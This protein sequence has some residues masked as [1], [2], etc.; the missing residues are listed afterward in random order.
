MRAVAV[1][2]RGLGLAVVLAALAAAPA[3]AQLPGG[4]CVGETEAA[5]VEQKPGP[6]VRYGVVPGVQAGQSGAA[7]AEAVPE[8]P[9]KTDR[10]LEL[11]RPRTG[12]LF[13]RLNRLFW[14]DGEEGIARFERLVRRYARRGYLIEVQLRYHPSPQQEGDI[15]AWTE[16]V[17][18]VVRRLGSHPAVRQLQVT[19]EVTITFSPDSSDG[20]Y[21]GARDALIEG[22]IAAQDEKRRRGFGQ[23]GIGF[24]W[25]YRLDPATESG[26]WGYLR[27]RGGARFVNALDWIGLDAYPGTFFPPAE[28]PG[29]ERDGMV[30][31]FSSLRC[32]AAIPGIPATVPIHV[33]ENGWPTSAARTPERQQTA[34]AAM[35]SAVHDFRGTYN[36]TDYRWH[37]LRDGDSADPRQEQ[38]YGL[39]R[40]DYSPK[41]A[42]DTVCRLFSR[43][44]TPGGGDDCD[45]AG[46][47]LRVVLKRQ[48]PRRCAVRATLRG[49][50]LPAVA[51]AVFRVNGHVVRRD[52]DAPFSARIWRRLHRGAPNRVRVFATLASGRVVKRRP[53]V[54]PCTPRG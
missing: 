39:M 49:A 20:A 24:N 11:L 26:F 22:V 38:Q 6:P 21:Q 52:R 50:D 44:S 51:H 31:A 53:S 45:S 46:P 41:P 37:N 12:V 25:F 13:V 15:G 40:D 33:N 36:I 14:S 19:N 28:Q 17:R 35:L 43:Y 4:A 34:A 18:E 1:A 3:S 23:L 27:D 5:A 7:P 16:Y 2:A 54:G 9:T 47:R 42:F 8:D 32:F 30:N 48:R 10:A 29:E